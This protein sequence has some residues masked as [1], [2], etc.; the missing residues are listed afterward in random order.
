M[1]IALSLAF[2]VLLGLLCGGGSIL[3]VPALDYAVG[4]DMRQ[5]IPV[6]LIVIGSTSALGAVPRIRA[7]QVQWRLAATVVSLIA[8]HLGAR[9]DTDRLQRWFAY[10]VFAVAAFVPIDTTSLR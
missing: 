6:S 9:A 10:L 1:T 2:G 5:A 3:A 4:L 8:G 7:R